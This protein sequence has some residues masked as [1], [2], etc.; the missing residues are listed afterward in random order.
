M[1]SMYFQMFLNDLIYWSVYTDHIKA[2]SFFGQEYKCAQQCKSKIK[3]KKWKH[4]HCVYCTCCAVLA[5]QLHIWHDKY[6]HRCVT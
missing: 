5:L 1:Y 2:N 4:S 6:R 3:V